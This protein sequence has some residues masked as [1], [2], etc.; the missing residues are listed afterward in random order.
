VAAA[1]RAYGVNRGDGVACLLTNG[2][3]ACAAVLGTWFAGAR[4]VSLPVM[5]RGMSPQAYAVQ[6][7]TLLSHCSADLLLADAPLVPHLNGFRLPVRVT[8]FQA[9]SGRV[10]FSPDPPAPNDPAFVQ[11]S[12]GSTTQP[13]GCVLTPAAVAAQVEMLAQHLAIDSERDT[14]VIW[15]PISHDMGLFGGVLLTYWTGHRLVLGTPERFLRAP[16]SWLND[17][18]AFGASVSAAPSFAL[19][20]ATRAARRQL[21]A[22]FPMRRMVI[23]G[24]RVD[25]E[26]LVRANGVLGEDRLPWRSLMPAYGL[27]EAVLAVTASGLEEGPQM[28]DVDAGALE[29]GEVEVVGRERTHTGTRTTR[30]V[31]AGRPLPGVCVEC[32]KSGVGEVLVRSPSMARGYLGDE[33][34][35][36][37]TFVRRGLRTG[38]LGFVHDDEL[39]IVGRPDDVFH[40]AGRNVYARDVEAA[41]CEVA[42]V[43]P[44]RCA[45]VATGRG[46]HPKVS[47]LI[48]RP[49]GGRAIDA[50]AR[51]VASA[52][53]RGAGVRVSE[54]VFVAPGTLPKTPSGKLQR[55]LC[56]TIA[57]SDPDEFPRVRPSL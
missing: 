4:V 47:A 34:S 42:E 51:D 29:R 45:V 6:I 7:H 57:T 1:L 11:Y 26:T 55:F 24:D 39:V 30:L 38:D 52:A 21:P 5:A 35:T 9:L 49:P 28:V 25:Y 23:G 43:R 36:A 46:P 17:C 31:T 10:D 3:E 48:E 18:A 2:F 19:D 32:S 20:L 8:A 33:A 16:H 37:K 53:L 56:R 22:P 50:V 44:G 13:R 41:L 15:L 12:S 54:C 40:L 27:A 14:G